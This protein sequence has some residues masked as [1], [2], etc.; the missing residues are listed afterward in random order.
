MNFF[1]DEKRIPDILGQWTENP[2][3]YCWSLHIAQKMAFDI[4]KIKN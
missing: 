4:F 1:R 2:Y 3:F